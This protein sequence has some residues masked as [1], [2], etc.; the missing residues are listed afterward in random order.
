MGAFELGVAGDANGDGKVNFADFLALST[1]FG[2]GRGW[3][4]GN[5]DGSDNGTQ[6]ADFLALSANFGFEEPGFIEIADARPAPAATSAGR[7]RGAG[8]L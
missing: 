4:E 5:F 7:D 1:N 6:F 3:S 8:D 2:T